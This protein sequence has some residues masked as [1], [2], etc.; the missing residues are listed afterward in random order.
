MRLGVRECLVGDRF[1]TGILGPI[2]AAVF[3]HVTLVSHDQIEIVPAA[4][5]P[6]AGAI[7]AALAAA[8]AA[9]S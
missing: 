6:E 4:L 2:R 1:V 8:E 9:G 5:G 3:E 7:G